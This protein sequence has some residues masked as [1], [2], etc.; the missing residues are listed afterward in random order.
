MTNDD[1]GHGVMVMV[2]YLKQLSPRIG[3]STRIILKL[4]KYIKSH[5]G[6]SQCSEYEYDDQSQGQGSNF[7]VKISKMV[8]FTAV[9]IKMPSNLT[10]ILKHLRGFHGMKN[11][12]P[13]Q[14]QEVKGQIFTIICLL[15]F[16]LVI[17]IL[18]VIKLHVY[19]KTLGGCH[20]VN[21]SSPV[22][23]EG[24][25]VKVKYSKLPILYY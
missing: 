7:K 13:D 8:I 19:V 12:N 23:G 4:G 10:D 5:E 1:Q 6:I 2:K 24:S 3:S 17:S 22:N 25:K 14:G 9:Q 20:S 18:V 15:L 21:D 11:E 16:S